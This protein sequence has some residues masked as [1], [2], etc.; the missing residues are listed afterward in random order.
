MKLKFFFFSYTTVIAQVEISEMDLEK[1]NSIDEMRQAMI[2]ATNEAALTVMG[3]T[4]EL[5]DLEMN[6]NL[7]QSVAE[8]WEKILA[9][10]KN[11][12]SENELTTFQ[13]I[14]SIGHLYN[15]LA[16]RNGEEQR[17]ESSKYEDMLD[18]IKDELEI[19][20][21]IVEVSHSRM[22]KEQKSLQAEQGCT[23]R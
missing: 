9:T 21:S 1:V 4:N 8:K 17:I 12:I 3:L 6:Y 20:Q 15:L 18:Y 19:L 16:T 10:T 2:K 23:K 5:A 7:A 22:E 13:L 14:D 11:F